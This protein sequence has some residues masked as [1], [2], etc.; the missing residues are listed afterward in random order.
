MTIV[1]TRKQNW[2]IKFGASYFDAIGK[3]VV[4]ALNVLEDISYHNDELPSFVLCEKK[5]GEDLFALRVW[6]G[7]D[8]HD[9]NN[10]V[11]V[12][13]LGLNVN[14][15]FDWNYCSSVEALFTDIIPMCTIESAEMKLNEQ[16]IIKLI[17][18]SQ[19]DFPKKLIDYIESE[20]L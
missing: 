13:A 12:F 16:N 4:E 8:D 19:V 3:P 11:F 18:Q 7:Y 2:E 10:E 9:E 1:Q 17:K 6:A 14:D 20:I 15:E 5:F